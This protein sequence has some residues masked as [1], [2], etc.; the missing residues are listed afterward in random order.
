MQNRTPQRATAPLPPH[1]ATVLPTWPHNTTTCSMHDCAKCTNTV[2]ATSPEATR[3]MHL[4]CNNALHRHTAQP[5]LGPSPLHSC[6]SCPLLPK[7]SKLHARLPADQPPHHTPQQ[8]CN[9]RP[10]QRAQHRTLQLTC[11]LLQH[12]WPC[13]CR[14]PPSQKSAKCPA[15]CAAAL[16]V[17]CPAAQ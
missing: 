9:P 4:A 14:P 6:L 11:L 16:A 10:P 1:T 7:L 2:H 5:T 15:A 13:C 3:R 8:D 17:L 12:C